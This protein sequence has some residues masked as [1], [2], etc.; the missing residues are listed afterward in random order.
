MSL[1]VDNEDIVPGD[2][3]NYK[4]M[5]FS[6][7]PNLASS[8]G[9]TNASWTLR[10]DLTSAY[11]CRLIKHMDSKGY[12]KAVPTVD[13]SKV[14]TDPLLDFSSGY[15]VRKSEELPKQGSEAPWRMY[16]NYILDV[17]SIN[18]GNVDD[19]ANITFS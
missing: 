8:F 6:G 9:Y 7:L 11:V 12:K 18:F 1:K 14:Q 4:G 2:L 3:L 13:R 5:M 17:F 10:C 16:Q 15:V 19:S